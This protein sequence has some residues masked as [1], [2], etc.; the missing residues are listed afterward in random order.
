[1]PASGPAAVSSRFAA[2]W[3]RWTEIVHLFA[4]RNDSRFSVDPQQYH[5][6][7]SELTE[8]ALGLAAEAGDA[9]EPLFG[10]I[11]EILAPW[12]QVDAFHW[13][14]QEIVNRLYARCLEI[15]AVLDDRA[16]FGGLQW[17][18]R[19]VI[20]AGAVLALGLAGI[21]L[22]NEG[23]EPQS[24]GWAIRRWLR[25]TFREVVGDTLEQQAV[26]GGLAL[27]A[28]I[29]VVVWYSAKRS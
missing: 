9:A 24:V 11:K 16:P 13:A 4:V 15:Q 19:F 27:V 22:V 14:E 6:L 7:H 3:R 28:I 21:M 23:V 10:E 18:V 1:M 25:R 2:R 29:M 8:L 20:L 12:V 17:G 26:V 5:A